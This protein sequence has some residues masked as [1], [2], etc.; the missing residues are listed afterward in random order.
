MCV[1]EVFK[2]M[3]FIRSY[4]VGYEW[5]YLTYVLMFVFEVLKEGIEYFVCV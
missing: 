2:I 3:I 1:I 4:R 5:L